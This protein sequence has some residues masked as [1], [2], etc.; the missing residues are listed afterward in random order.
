MKLYSVKD[1]LSAL[2]FAGAAI[3]YALYDLQRP[4]RSKGSALLL[5]ALALSCIVDS[6]RIAF[7]KE[8]YEKEQRKRGQRKTVLRRR[9]GIF[10][11]LMPLLGTILMLLVLVLV[12]FVPMDVPLLLTVGLGG[13]AAATLYNCWLNDWQERAAAKLIA[14][15]EANDDASPEE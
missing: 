4:Y 7:S 13:V 1:L 12:H 9:F 6:L 3:A 15:E 10:A 8:L 2:L 14:E 11:P 5:L